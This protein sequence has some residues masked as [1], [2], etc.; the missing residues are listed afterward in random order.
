M[1]EYLDINILGTIPYLI[2]EDIKMTESVAM[3][4]YLVEKYGPTDLRVM[5]DEK[6][7]PSIK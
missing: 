2:D 5:P 1:K 3:T 4:Q 7:Y 6:D